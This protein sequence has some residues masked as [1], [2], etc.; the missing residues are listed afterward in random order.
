MIIL[1]KKI[2]LW[3]EEL[4]NL[5]IPALQMR[6]TDASVVRICGALLSQRPFHEG[7]PLFCEAT[8]TLTVCLLR[9]GAS[10]AQPSHSSAIQPLSSLDFPTEP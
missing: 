9:I 6:T 4:N 2:F 5:G 10:R 1:I 7:R 8:S 3:A